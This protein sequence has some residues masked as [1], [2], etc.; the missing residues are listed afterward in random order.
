MGSSGQVGIQVIARAA[1]ILRAL[2]NEAVGLS[3]GEIAN[4]VE[5]PRSTVQRIV[6][7]LIDEQLL[8]SATPTSGV[9]LGP[10][11][12]RLA[13][14]TS[15]DYTEIIHPFMEQLSSDVN[16][17]VDLSVLQ[18]KFAVFVDQVPCNHRLR[19]VSAVGERFPL[20]STACGKMFLAHA[21]SDE[22]DR[23]LSGRLEATTEST[24]T[25]I[26]VL[27][28]E[29]DQVRAD[30]VAYDLDE[31]TEGISALGAAFRDPIGRLYSLSI[32]APSTRFV[33][34]RQQIKNSL[35]KYRDRIAKALGSVEASK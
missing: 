1:S 26:D 7:A 35:L 17:T 23:L 18:D 24:I 34:N 32:P 19:A 12:L 6:G 10:A 5:L 15:Q 21:T 30:G 4:K 31:H 16:E 33:H 13:G 27:K 28:L 9:K 8:I 11:L 2:E 20:H 3:L 14:A 25:D 22:L 29:L